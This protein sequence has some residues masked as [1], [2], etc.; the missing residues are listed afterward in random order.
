MLEKVSDLAKDTVVGRVHAEL[1]VRGADIVLAVQAETPIPNAH[2]SRAQ[3]HEHT[4]FSIILKI[5]QT[6]D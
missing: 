2:V 5:I 1:R 3:S 4:C 6:P